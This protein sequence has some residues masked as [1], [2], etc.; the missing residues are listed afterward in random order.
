MNPLLL[1]TGP[2][3]IGK[4]TALRRVCER[5]SIAPLR[6]FYT[7]EVRSGGVRQGFCLV[8]FDGERRLIADVRF[9]PPRVGKYGVDVAAI[10]DIAR[11]V[12]APDPAVRLFVIDEIGKM[13]CLS[14][15]FVNAVDNLLALGR[16]LLATVALRGEGL[17]E[18]TLRQR[19]R[20]NG[21][22]RHRFAQILLHELDR[23]V[24]G[25]H[26]PAGVA[27]LERSAA[28]RAAPSGRFRR[29]SRRAR[30]SSRASRSVAT[31]RSRSGGWTRRSRSRHRIASV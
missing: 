18:M 9:G 21:S 12:L 15:E 25:A 13:E 20:S 17:I 1:L 7:E 30:S 2:P 28:R 29:S 11:R 10:D 4:T 14:A 16:P 3:G 5:L 22:F 6:G 26:A 19:T 8:T 31:I 27:P 23:A 24:F